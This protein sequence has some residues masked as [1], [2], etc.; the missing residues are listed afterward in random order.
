MRKLDLK[1]RRF[2]HLVARHL[3]AGRK[4]KHYTAT[5]WVCDCDCGRQGEAVT[6]HLTSGATIS[7]GNNGC[8][9]HNPIRS[10]DPQESSLR[11]LYQNYKC[12]AKNRGYKFELSLEQFRKFTKQSCNYCGGGPNTEYLHKWAGIKP[13]FTKNRPYVYNGVDR[14]EN[15]VGYI[16]GNCVTCCKIC[17][18]MKQGLTKEEFLNHIRRISQ[19]TE[20]IV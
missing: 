5:T 16:E 4:W 14:V 13:D 15:A 10:E 7:C 2:G 12:N 3:G 18:I 11:Y 19:H 1:D 9:F 6:S 17:N 20:R 8:E